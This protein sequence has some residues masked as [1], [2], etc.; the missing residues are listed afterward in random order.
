MKIVFKMI[1]LYGFKWSSLIKKRF[2]I[3]KSYF[4][5]DIIGFINYN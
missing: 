5:A 1:E 4:F 2:S 3:A